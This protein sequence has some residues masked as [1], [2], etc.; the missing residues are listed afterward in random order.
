VEF[1]FSDYVVDVGVRE[2]RRHGEPVALEPQVFDLLV[3]LLQN[4]DHV[5][6]K[7]DLLAAVW[8][9]RIVSDAAITTR[10]NALRR[11][12]GDSGET[13]RLIRTMP[14]KGIRFV[15][16]VREEQEPLSAS[17]TVPRLSIVVLPFVNLS[18]DP[19]Q[20]YFAD[21]VTDDLII[22]LSR[23]VGAFVIARSTAFTYKGKSVDVK[24]I[25]RELGVH[26]VLEGS[27]RR[28][29]E[30]VHVNVQLIDAE[31]GAHL[32]A[33]RFETDRTDL[34]RAHREITGRLA[35]ALNLELVRDVGRR[36]EQESRIESAAQDLVMLGWSWW[37][38]PRSA[39]AMQEARRAFER[40]LEIDPRSIDARVGLGR[41]LTVN[42]VGNFAP[43]P[44][45]DFQQ[46]A[47][48]IE[49]LLIEAIEGDPSNPRARA[50]MGRLRWVQNRLAE[51]RIEFETAIAL[52]PNDSFAHVQLALTLLYS[53]E[54]AAA[55]PEAE[56]AIRLSPRDPQ[57]WG[58]YWP[59]GFCR[60][61]LNEAHAAIEL[62]R[63]AR[64]T[65]PRNWL[66]HFLLAAALGLQGDL[67]EAKAALAESVGRNPDV[68]S[69]AAYRAFR[70]WGSPQYWALFEKTAAAGLRRAGFSDETLEPDRVL[71]T[72]LFTDI[73]DS[74]RRAIEIGDREWRRLLDR[75]DEA[76]RQELARYRGRE[77]K[78]LGDGF[79]ATF[80]GPARAVR[81]A[82]A[83]IDRMR[84]IGI[85]VRAG[86]H[87]GEVEI[88]RGEVSG[89]AVHIAA[90]IAELAEGGG[91]LVSTTVRDLVAGAD[92]SF[93]DRGDHALR[94]LPQSVRLFAAKA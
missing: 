11:A 80:D 86:L 4:R 75:H 5:V 29:S 93:D 18:S 84:S 32:W 81:C 63:R 52:D 23:I 15:G 8:G 94:G 64:A 85:S 6:S 92:L 10:V 61:L 16:V 36:I 22:D 87:T 83:I 31:S 70:P 57:L 35:W 48:R 3:Y 50:T 34:A 17:S 89:V 76:I 74:T 40:A 51:A 67:G 47:Q 24:E 26:Y 41:V 55:I 82:A 33:D 25:G 9:G 91:I 49:R 30:Q 37:H 62:L 28:A 65:N 59:L 46:E 21:G 38:R 69:L 39:A 88:K 77:V 90:R 7:D 42:L 2:L 14:R 43:R 54:P 13:Q 68:D 1:A 19:E 56:M 79:L 45:N 53:G 71:A 58:Y 72:V 44:E 20:E 60:L 27:V 73:V 78:T 66:I 12:L